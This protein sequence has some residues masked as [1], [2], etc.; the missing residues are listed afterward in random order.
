MGIWF[1]QCGSED[2]VLKLVKH[3]SSRPSA[4]READCVE[5]LFREHPD[6]VHDASVAFP[7]KILHLLGDGGARRFDLIVMDRA[8]GQMLA[9]AI[10]DKWRGGCVAELMAIL[11]KVGSCLSTFQKRY[12]KNH[13]DM[14]PQNVFYDDRSGRVTLI[15]IG[16]MGCKTDST[17]VE[18]F[19]RSLRQLA[20]FYGPQLATEGVQRFQTG[21][22]QSLDTLLSSRRGA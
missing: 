15:D 21:H 6:I 7:C 3:D 18:H 4:L 9:N 8:P 19:T 14:A 13:G 5:R 16:G 22:A 11:E 12:G 2:L 10:G 20:P 1:V 17:D